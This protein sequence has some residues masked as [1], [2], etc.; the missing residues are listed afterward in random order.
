MAP[1]P[2]ALLSL[3]K[4]RCLFLAHLPRPLLHWYNNCLLDYHSHFLALPYS[5]R[6]AGTSGQSFS[7]ILKYLNKNIKNWTI[8]K[9][10][11]LL[12]FFSTVHSSKIF[13]MISKGETKWSRQFGSI[14]SNSWKEMCN[15]RCPESTFLFKISPNNCF[16][17]FNNQIWIPIYNALPSEAL[18]ATKTTTPLSA[19]RRPRYGSSDGRMIMKMMSAYLFKNGCKY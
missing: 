14:Y 15:G 6:F 5:G 13:R 3:L 1:T 17:S 4:H 12:I 7:E 9:I 8:Y 16:I 2:L 10:K 11:T 19:A 18:V